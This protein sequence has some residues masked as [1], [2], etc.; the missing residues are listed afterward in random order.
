MEPTK[1]QCKAEKQEKI[2]TIL[3]AMSYELKISDRQSAEKMNNTYSNCYS[4][5]KKL[6]E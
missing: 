5:E 4:M 6:L 1:N 2:K 3:M